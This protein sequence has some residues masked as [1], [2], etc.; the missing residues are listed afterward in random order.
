M[1]EMQQGDAIKASYSNPSWLPQSRQG[2]EA[3]EH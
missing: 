1:A 3:G 2:A